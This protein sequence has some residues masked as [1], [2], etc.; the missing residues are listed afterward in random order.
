MK[1][2]I[3][4]QDN[5]K[6]IIKPERSVLPHNLLRFTLVILLYGTM[7]M[8][9]TSLAAQCSV[10]FLTCPTLVTLIDCDHSLNEPFILPPVIANPYGTCQGFNLVKTGG[11]AVGTTVPL[12]TYQVSYQAQGLDANQQVITSVNCIFSVQIVPDLQ[13]PTF[14]FCPP[15][16]TVNGIF[17]NSGNC[18][19]PAQWPL[20]ICMDPCGSSLIQTSNLQCGDAFPQGTSQV[21]YTASDPSNNT[22]TCVFT[23]TVLC[24][25]STYD[26]EKLL[27]PI[28]LYP[29]PNT[30]L[31]SLELPM[32]ATAQ[33][34]FRIL[35][36]TGRLM[37]ESKAQAGVERQS[38]DAGSLPDGMY[39]VQVVVEGRVIGVEKMVKQ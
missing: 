23:V 15:N 20:P 5:I 39:F 12:G 2:S 25:S 28:H 31:F 4:D 36:I 8:F 22:S 37:Q 1:I 6:R 16:I 30:G 18:T 11:P 7:L 19:A 24:P 26:G 3:V 35:D 13:G 10:A 33:M 9:R 34:R 38:L 17:D 27:S 21:T 29:N 32:P 14:S